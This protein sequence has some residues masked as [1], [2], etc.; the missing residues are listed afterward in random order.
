MAVKCHT[1]IDAMSDYDWRQG[2]GVG[3]VCSGHPPLVRT[4]RVM[5][6]RP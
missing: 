1:F 6:P 3:Y 4:G 5:A 2:V